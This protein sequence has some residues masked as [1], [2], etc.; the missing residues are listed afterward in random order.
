M[1]VIHRLPPFCAFQTH[2]FLEH[3]AENYAPC[4]VVTFCSDTGALEKTQVRDRE[5]LLS[6]AAY[7]INLD[8]F[9]I[10]YT[11]TFLDYI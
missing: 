4:L 9:M 1:N 3:S 8:S 7:H 6:T 10:I 5:I 11:Y 2:V